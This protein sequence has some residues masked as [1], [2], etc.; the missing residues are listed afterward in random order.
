MLD[1]TQALPKPP[2]LLLPLSLLSEQGAYS[3]LPFS[4]GFPVPASLGTYSPQQLIKA[5]SYKDGFVPK[6]NS[7][8][9]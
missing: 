4:P 6:R 2:A 7:P 5:F 8:R 1:P 3:T 9:C